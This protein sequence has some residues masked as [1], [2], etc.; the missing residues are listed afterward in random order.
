M[1]LKEGHRTSGPLL[2]IPFIFWILDQIAPAEY[3]AD[4]MISNTQPLH[5]SMIAYSFVAFEWLWRWE[6]KLIV[7]V[8][9][10]V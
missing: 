2:R 7:A 5:C 4:V 3:N 10:S 6:I 1:V 8:F 9:I